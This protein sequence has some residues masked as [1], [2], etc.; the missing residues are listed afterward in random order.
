LE[1]SVDWSFWSQYGNY[2][3]VLGLAVSLL[4]FAFTIWQ[5]IK[6]RKAAEEAR[7]IAR[8]AIN[9]VSSESFFTQVGTAIRLIQ[10]L[11]NFSRLKQWHRTIDRCA[12][13]TC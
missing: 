9:R 1:V 2:A 10:E 3:S 13:F 8:E 6:S 7:V 12:G 11:R 4:G 5:V